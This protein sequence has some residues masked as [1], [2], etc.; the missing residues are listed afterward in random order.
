[1]KIV[2]I[3]DEKLYAFHFDNE[4]QDEFRKL[5]NRWTDPE[6]LEDFFEN[7]KADLIDGYFGTIEVEKAILETMEYADYLEDLILECIE[8]KEQLKTLDEL[9][10]PLQNTQLRILHLNKSK[11]RYNWLRIY[12]L[13]IDQNAYLITGGAIKLTQ[14]MQDRPHTNDELLKLEQCR[15]YLLEEGIVDIDGIIDEVET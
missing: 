10:K 13:R 15:N 3:F 7:N 4:E 12:A 6:F 1:M 5:F 11:T 14:T 2:P 8:I 9:F